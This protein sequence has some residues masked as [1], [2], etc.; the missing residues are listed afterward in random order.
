MLVVLT[1]RRPS[2]QALGKHQDTQF[3]LQSNVA[4]PGT[5]PRRYLDD[6]LGDS[7]RLLGVREWPAVCILARVQ[8]GRC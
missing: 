3:H 1:L 7:V 6:R 2:G 5:I 4:K 8:F